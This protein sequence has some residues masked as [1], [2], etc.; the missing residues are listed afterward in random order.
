MIRK[1]RVHFYKPFQ[2]AE[3]LFHGRT[4]RKIDLTDLESYRSI[5][6]RW[7]DEVSRRLVGRVSTSSARFQD[8]VFDENAMPPRC[9]AAL[10]VINKQSKGGVE[11]YVYRSFA[12]KLDK[13]NAVRRYV[14]A[15]DADSFSLEELV[16]LVVADP[17][18]RR[19][20]DKIYEITVFA[21]FSTIV[22]ALEVQVTLELGKVD[23]EILKDFSRFTETILGLMEGEVKVTV[24]A[25]LYR[26]G[27]TNAAD[28]GLDM[29]SN[30]GPAVQVKHLTLTSE[31]MGDVVDAVKADKIVVVCLGAEK[32]LVESLLKQVDYMD[33][34][35]GIIT[36]ED[37][38]G[39][40][41]L[42]LS[43]KY[44]TTLGSQL[45]NDLRR[46]FEDEFPAS[47]EV[48]P[49]MKERGYD[50]LSLPAGWSIDA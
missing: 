14:M 7:R 20:V 39:W 31:L 33:R 23:K 30:F 48:E 38:N 18:L 24:P 17:G 47:I 28:R 45:L 10:G 15:S 43:K 13:L 46:E 35:Q 1:S 40:Y 36:M 5:S 16:H 4:S 11:A 22:R 19:S 29:W 44:R 27:V 9:L 49:F 25:A 42:C 37:L 32:E 26:V 2:I 21:L 8:N 34:V 3:V 41:S 6:K 50:K 12:Q